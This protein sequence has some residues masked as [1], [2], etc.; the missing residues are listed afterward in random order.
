[1]K[2]APSHEPMYGVNNI[3]VLFE[4]LHSQLIIFMGQFFASAG[5]D[6]DEVLGVNLS[7]CSALIYPADCLIIEARWL[8]W[9]SNRILVFLHILVPKQ[10]P[11]SF[12]SLS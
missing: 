8:V 9:L 10:T 5:N 12:P 11:R 7:R 4:A 1:M 3:L 6:Y 2:T